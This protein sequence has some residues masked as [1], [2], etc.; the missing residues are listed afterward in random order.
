MVWD[1]KTFSILSANSADDK[2]N[3]PESRVWHFVQI[4]SSLSNLG[5]FVWLWFCYFIYM[6]F[7]QSL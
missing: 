5:M 1:L 4:V 2:L 3:F 7:M 6:F